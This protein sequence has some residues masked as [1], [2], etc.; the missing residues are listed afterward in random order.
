MLPI[1]CT[2]QVKVVILGQDPYHD[3]G[4]AMGLSFSV[5]PGLRVPP[6]LQ[7]MYKELRD[8][9]GCALPNHGNLE[10]WATQVR[11]YTG[12]GIQGLG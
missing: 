12:L 1:V 3:D 5:P 2:P 7:N 10:K 9:C 11:A 6:S 4:Q 8:D